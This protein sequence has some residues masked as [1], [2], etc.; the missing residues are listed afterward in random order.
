MQILLIFNLLFFVLLINLLKFAHLCR[1]QKRKWLLVPMRDRERPSGPLADSPSSL[2]LWGGCLLLTA[3]DQIWLTKIN[4][5]AL[6]S[7]Q[8]NLATV[9][10]RNKRAHCQQGSAHFNAYSIPF[11]HI[12]SVIK[13]CIFNYLK[14]LLFFLIL[15][16]WSHWIADQT[17]GALLWII[18]CLISLD[19][20]VS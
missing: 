2:F 9:L 19:L 6:T 17:L 16:F 4:G 14:V 15:F 13:Q 5:Q 3:T 20:K 8:L 10:A 11:I 1:E 18:T 7:D 12:M